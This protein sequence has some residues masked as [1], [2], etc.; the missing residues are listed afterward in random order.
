MPAIAPKPLPTSSAAAAS[1]PV[2]ASPAAAIPWLADLPQ[3]IRQ[4][5]P[6]LTISGTVYSDNPAQR[7]LVVNG[8]VVAQGSEVAPELLLAEIHPTHSEF[9]YRGT[10]FRL[11]H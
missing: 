5:V 7:M 9:V 4:Q 1:H 3:D 6:K 11:A 2:A 8:Q 10:R